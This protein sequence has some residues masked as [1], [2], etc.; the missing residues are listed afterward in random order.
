MPVQVT[1]FYGF[2]DNEA[3]A[4]K[5]RRLYLLSIGYVA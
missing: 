5:L 2:P 4:I 3:T 1:A